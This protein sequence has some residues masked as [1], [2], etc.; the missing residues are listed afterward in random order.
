MKD[1]SEKLYLTLEI[2]LREYL[3]G[4]CRPSLASIARKLDIAQSVFSGRIQLLK[5][6]GYISEST[7]THTGL[8]FTAK[9]LVLFM[10]FKATN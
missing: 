2:T 9:T 3:A 1:L 5:A 7:G 10:E 4:P 8:G 6:L